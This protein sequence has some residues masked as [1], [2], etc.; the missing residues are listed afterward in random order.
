MKDSKYVGRAEVI[1]IN[2]YTV[3]INNQYY[4][5]AMSLSLIIN[6]YCYSSWIFIDSISFI[7]YV[8]LN[9]RIWIAFLPQLMSYYSSVQSRSLSYPS[10][11][12]LPD[13]CHWGKNLTMP[14]PWLTCFKSTSH[15]L[16]KSK[17]RFHSRKY[18]SPWQ[19]FQTQYPVTLSF[20][21]PFVEFAC[22]SLTQIMWQVHKEEWGEWHAFKENHDADS[23][24]WNVWVLSFTFTLS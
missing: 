17:L 4:W 1:N 13:S 7:P 3:I 16:R 8:L 20:Q 19:H 15:T 12:P 6:V 24:I 23:M 10:H 14:F 5:I 18:V 21:N 9:K 2:N 22:V 11:V